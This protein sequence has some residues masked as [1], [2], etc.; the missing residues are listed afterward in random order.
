MPEK[1]EAVLKVARLWNEAM[2]KFNDPGSDDIDEL[3]PIAKYDDA[4]VESA[5]VCER[6][7]K[8][9][10]IGDMAYMPQNTTELHGSVEG[11]VIHEIGS[12]VSKHSKQEIV[13]TGSSFVNL[14]NVFSCGA[15]QKKYYDG[16]ITTMSAARAGKNPLLVLEVAFTHERLAEHILEYASY[17]TTYVADCMY[18]IGVYMPPRTSRFELYLLCVEKS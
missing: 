11:L 9:F 16:K 15:I 5:E 7:C 17:L 1:R 6:P 13:C 10:V 12:C 4:F 3:V 8:F 18:A 14:A 2:A